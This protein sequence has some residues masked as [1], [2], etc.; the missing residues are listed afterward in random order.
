[1]I[2]LTSMRAVTV[3]PRARVAKVGGGALLRHLNANIPPSRS[4]PAASAG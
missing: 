3:D 1:M 2:D 4:Q